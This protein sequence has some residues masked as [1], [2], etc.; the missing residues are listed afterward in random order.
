MTSQDVE[1]SD[2]ELAWI[3]RAQAGDRAAFSRLVGVYQTPVYNLAY[4]M[5]GNAAEAEDAAQETFL[6]AY[7]RLHTYRSEHKFSTWI[8]SIAS[9]YCVDRLRRRH[10]IWLSTD[11]EPVQEVIQAYAT[12][13]SPESAALDAES[14]AEVQAML[15]IL[16]PMY[17]TPLILRYWHDLSYKEI[18]EVMGVTEATVKTRLHR[19]RLQLAE[20][21]NSS[22]RA[23]AGLSPMPPPAGTAMSSPTVRT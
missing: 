2:Q 17:R 18:A 14:R 6:R 13:E 9:H 15:N 23:R 8:L 5:L 7:T 19:A 11:E 20:Y 1:V 12:A 4:R 3:Q 22:S 10:F 21:M 16:D